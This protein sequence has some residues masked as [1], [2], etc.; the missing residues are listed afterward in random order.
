M[1]N[2]VELTIALPSQVYLTKKVPEVLIPAVRAD[3]DIIPGRAPS[4]FV[5]DYGVVQI[6][7]H[8]GTAKERYFIKS[9]AADIADNKCM[10]LTQKVV[11]YDSITPHD[12]K[13]AVE[14]AENE[15]EKLF[16]EMILDYQRGVRRRYLRTLNIF[17][18]KT[19]GQ[20]SYEETV[21]DIRE[22]LD[23]LRKR[24]PK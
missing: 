5:L 7:G 20:K 14:N 12:A 10:V 9:G 8:D 17:S 11:P 1:E 15:D 2:E 4:V 23:E 19:R 21:V 16:Y 13:K 6:L 24:F 22:K 18:S 3:V